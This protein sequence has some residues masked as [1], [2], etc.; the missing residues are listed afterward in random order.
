MSNLMK[1]NKYKIKNKIFSGGCMCSEKCNNFY[2]EIDKDGNFRNK[3]NIITIDKNNIL[4]EGNYG[5]IY[6]GIINNPE[7]NTINNIAVKIIDIEQIPIDTKEHSIINFLCEEINNLC[8]IKERNIIEY[9]GYSLYQDKFYIFLE[10]INGVTLN[11]YLLN[12]D[13]SCIKKIAIMRQLIEGINDIHKYNI[14][15]NDITADNIM[16][17]DIDEN[18]I[19]IKYIDFGFSCIYPCDESV[20]GK[21]MSNVSKEKDMTSLYNIFKEKF[22]H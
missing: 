7:T 9:Y 2:Y 17:I 12:K 20:I 22:F 16:V 8:N 4:G 1:Y 11:K 3:T 14:I 18:N 15:H 10:Y 21:L 13:L 19:L 5:E 6:K